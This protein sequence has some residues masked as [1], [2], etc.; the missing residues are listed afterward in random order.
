[1]EKEITGVLRTK[2]SLLIID[3]VNDIE[4]LWN[5]VSLHWALKDLAG[6]RCLIT[7]C[8]SEAQV[9]ALGH[10]VNCVT[11]TLEDN[12]AV[13]TNILARRASDGSQ[14]QLAD[15]FKVRSLCS[16]WKKSMPDICGGLNVIQLFDPTAHQWADDGTG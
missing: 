16:A 12:A 15:D 7:T 11:L 4:S 8:A 5:G 3:N 9:A 1:L 14:T 10:G 6:T 2:R 13:M